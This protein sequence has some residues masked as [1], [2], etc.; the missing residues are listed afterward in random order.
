[1]SRDEGE[2]RRRTGFDIRDFEDAI[3][4]IYKQFEDKEKP[5]VIRVEGPSERK[6]EEV[7]DTN[8]E[9]LRLGS[10]VQHLRNQF[11]RFL[12]VDI[13]EESVNH[14]VEAIRGIDEI[15]EVYA[16]H[17]SGGIVFWIFYDR[18]DRIDVLEKVVDV[19]CDFERIFA[20]LGFDYRIL[21]YSDLNSRL[22]SQGELIY[23]RR[24]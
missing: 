1:M 5:I 17:E 22:A 21:P 18:G 16:Y 23:R 19:E 10:E 11:N 8:K 15:N 6:K 4:S 13:R 3:Y 2:F 24:E 9:I 20:S 7:I 12:K 14:F